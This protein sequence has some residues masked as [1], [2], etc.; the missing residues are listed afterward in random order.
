MGIH[1]IRRREMKAQKVDVNNLPLDSVYFY[2]DGRPKLGR[3]FN[4]DGI[5]C[6]IWGDEVKSYITQDDMIKAFALGEKK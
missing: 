6:D 3:I 1:C 4:L 2:E 5:A